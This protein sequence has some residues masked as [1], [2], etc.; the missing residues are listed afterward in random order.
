M[1]TR[2]DSGW[3]DSEREQVCLQRHVL[4]IWITPSSCICKLH[5]E[6]LHDY[7]CQRMSRDLTK[8]SRAGVLQ[9]IFSVHFRV[10]AINNFGKILIYKASLSTQWPDKTPLLSRSGVFLAT[11]RRSQVPAADKLNI[12]TLGWFSQTSPDAD[13]WNGHRLIFLGNNKVKNNWLIFRGLMSSA[14]RIGE[15]GSSRPAIWKVRLFLF[16][17]HLPQTGS[18]AHQKKRKEKKMKK[19]KSQL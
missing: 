18:P 7:F 13:R 1:S 14:A 17:R 4:K 16:H 9:L 6:T 11:A 19:K 15:G 5:K 8:S 10:D 12:L 3:L 2:L